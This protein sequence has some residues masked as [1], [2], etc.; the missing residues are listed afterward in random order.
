MLFKYVCTEIIG[1]VELTTLMQLT[2]VVTESIKQT[3]LE[4]NSYTKKDLR[5]KTEMQFRPRWKFF[6]NE[7][8][9]LS[10]I[11]IPKKN[12]Q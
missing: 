6:K 12:W 8:W 5:R 9:W 2:R 7:K 3:L 10:L 4:I 1:K 11:P